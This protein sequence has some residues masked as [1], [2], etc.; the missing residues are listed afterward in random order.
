MYGKIYNNKKEMFITARVVAWNKLIKKSIIDETKTIFPKG[1]RYEDVEFFYKI[2]PYINKV[3]FVK[4]PF[5]H[6][7]QR[8]SSI[9]NTQNEKTKDIFNILNNVLEF[10]KE[11]NLYEEY[12]EELEYMY[13]RYLLQSSFLRM[14]KIQDKSVRRS[15][16]EET[17]NLLNNTFPNWKKNGILNKNKT[18]KNMYLKTVNVHTFHLY[19]KLFRIM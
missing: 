12:K 6:Y 14:I 18:S 1:L 15:C 13:A 3:S 16:L 9:S 17:W 10:Y 4:E 7:I 2:L 19:A 5:I 11:S 8:D